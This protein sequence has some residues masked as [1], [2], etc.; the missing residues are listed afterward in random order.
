MIQEA[1][2]KLVDKQDLTYKEA[3]AVIDEI[4]SGKTAPTLTAAFLAAL[5]TK[6]SRAEAIDEIAGRADAVRSRSIPF[7]YD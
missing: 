4:M 2:F 3:Y 6:S 1:I 7:T 5:S